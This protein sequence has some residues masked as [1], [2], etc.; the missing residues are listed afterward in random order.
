MSAT[1][2]AAAAARLLRP[3]RHRSTQWRRPAFIATAVQPGQP[4]TW[5]ARAASIKRAD[6]KPQFGHRTFAS[7]PSSLILRASSQSTMSNC[8]PL[9]S[10]PTRQHRTCLSLT[11]SPQSPKHLPHSTSLAS[12]T[13]PSPSLPL[14]SP[15]LKAMYRSTIPLLASI[16]H[17]TYP[18]HSPHASSHSTPATTPLHHH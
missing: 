6:M 13:P 2:A 3:P 17:H 10:V 15:A 18:I 12:Q 9:H 7:A 4:E 8:Y 1:A 14:V 5:Q 11:V 16:P